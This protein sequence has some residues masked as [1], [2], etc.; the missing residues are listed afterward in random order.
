MERETEDKFTAAG[1]GAGTLETA[2][3][4]VE[5]VAALAVSP[6]PE[7]LDRTALLLQ[8]AIACLTAVRDRSGCA[9]DG[10][11]QARELKRIQ[12]AIQ[13]AGA[14]LRKAQ[15]YHSGWSGY[16]GA[17]TGGY[18]AGGQPAPLARPSRFWVEG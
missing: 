6:A 18:R 17:R 14:L 13:T 5:E 4:A 3:A 9:S 15:Q 1:E 11:G 12:R 8:S 16:L 7:V 10:V 2:R